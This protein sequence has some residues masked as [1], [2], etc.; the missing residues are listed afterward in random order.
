MIPKVFGGWK[1]MGKKSK[2][3]ARAGLRSSQRHGSTMTNVVKSDLFD[4]V[5]D[6]VKAN[7][8]NGTPSIDES[9]R[10]LYS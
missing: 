3:V 7:H 2:L 1:T 10:I 6:V 9:C 5:R 8:W 4:M